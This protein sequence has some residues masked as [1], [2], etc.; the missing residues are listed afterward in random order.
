MFILL[1]GIASSPGTVWTS[2]CGSFGMD[3][4]SGHQMD[5]R[6]WHEGGNREKENIYVTRSLGKKKD[7]LQP[8]IVLHQ[9]LHSIMEHC[10][11]VLGLIKALVFTLLF[12]SPQSDRKPFVIV[13]SSDSNLI[14]KL[15]DYSHY[16]AIW[17]TS[18]D[19]VCC[20][21]IGTRTSIMRCD[22]IQRTEIKLSGLASC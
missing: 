5:Q 16:R 4:S 10:H 11:V 12:L 6:Y 8:K 1:P 13:L 7:K 2:E 18:V 17:I 9:S 21:H 3:L 19:I 14:R 22:C 15:S 20:L